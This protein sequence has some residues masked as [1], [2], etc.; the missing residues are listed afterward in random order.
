LAFHRNSEPIQFR[1]INSQFDHHQTAE[2]G[3]AILL[4]YK[5]SLLRLH[6]STSTA[7]SSIGRSMMARSRSIFSSLIRFSQAMYRNAEFVIVFIMR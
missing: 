5:Q 2:L 1:C 4:D 6:K 3:I 7:A